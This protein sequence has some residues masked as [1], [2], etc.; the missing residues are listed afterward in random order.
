MSNKVTL[1]ISVYNKITALQ[2][3]F[4]SLKRQSFKDFEVIVADDGSAT[5]FCEELNQL[6]PKLPFKVQHIWQEDNG[7]QKNKIL[8]KAVL[9]AQTDYLIFIDG[10]C[11]LHSKFMEEH[12]K[13]SK[14]NQCLAGRRA[15]LSQTMSVALTEETVAN[16]FL[17]NNFIGLFADALQKKANMIEKSIYLPPSMLRNWLNRKPARILGCNFSLYRKDLLA[18]NG[19]DERYVYPG[20]G[21]DVDIENRL[22]LNGVRIQKLNYAA[23]QYHLYHKELPRN[24]ENR[25][26]YE[27]I[28]NQ[29]VICTPFGIQKTA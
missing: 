24:E 21:E 29:K 18:I 26:L 22:K 16:G 8:N 15:N 17:E 10:D 4:A 12:Y 23:I 1:I 25:K 11:V 2:L 5:T 13:N 7:F 14:P 27:Y 28:T 3:I 6:L 19:F 9:A 20:Y